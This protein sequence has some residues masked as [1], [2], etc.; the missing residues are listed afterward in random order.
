[1]NEWLKKLF[2]Q[3]KGLWSK[4][5]IIQKI[6]LIGIVAAVIAGLILVSVLSSRPTT[7][8]LFSIP[9]TDETMRDKIVYRLSQENV[10]VSL[11]DAGMISVDDEATARRMRS[12]LVREDLVPGNV[13]PWNL[14][15]IERWTITDFQQNVN[16]QRSITAQITRH[17]ESL[18]EI[19]R[20]EVVLGMPEKSLFSADQKPVTASVILMIKPGSDFSENK[21]KVEGVQ[22]LLIMA[23]PGLKAE[24]ITIVDTSGTVLNNFAEKAASERVDIIAKEQKLIEQLENAYSKKIL[25]TLQQN[26]DRDRVRN[27]NIKIDMDMSKKEV[28]STEYFPFTLRPDNQ[29]T[30]YDDSELFPSVTLSSQTIDKIWKGTVYNPEGPSG[31]EGQNPPVYSDMTN[32]YGINQEKSETKNQAINTRQTQEIKSP[33][34]DRVTVSVNIDGVWKRKTDPASGK[35]VITPAGSI[36][37]EYVPVAPEDLDKAKLLVQDAIGYNRTR[38]DSVTVTNIAVDRTAQF[39]AEDIAYLR[40]EQTRRTILLSVIGV[41]AVLIAFILFRIISREME[42]RRRL[43]EEELLRQHQ[44]EREKTLWEAEQAGMEVTMSVEERERAELQESVLSIAREHPE[45]VAMLIRTWLMEEE[46]VGN[47]RKGRL[48]GRRRSEK[49]SGF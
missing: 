46:N 17:I 37:R 43:R 5:S 4:W 14:F 42:R 1:M 24:N 3:V 22:K 15:D 6:I 23:V 18:D 31:T 47:K 34:I 33:A 21:N 44:L 49:S 20:A 28:N 41:I 25:E 2:S 13:D 29:D 27:I 19:D 8:P 39:A 35:I 36:E 12:I 7:V 38:G 9:V 10:K 40:A 45:D 48:L 11:S 16:L 30:P 32:M 26:F